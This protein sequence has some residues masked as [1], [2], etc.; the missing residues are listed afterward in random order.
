[1]PELQRRLL[2]NEADALLIS[3]E[4]LANDEF[5]DNVLSRI[6]A[7]IGLLE[8]DEAHCISDWGHD[9]RPDYKRLLN[10]LK[11]LPAN[12]PVVGTT[13]TANDR[14]IK[15]IESQLGGIR[16]QR[17]NLARKSL[18]LQ[19]IRM[20]TQA[21]R[22]A[23]ISDHINSLPGTGIIYVL[24]K[25]D[26]ENVARWLQKHGVLAKPYYGDVKSEE[27]P[28]SND[29]RLHLEEQLLQNKLKAVV[30]TTALGMGYDKP[31]LGFVVHYQAPGSIVGYYQQVGRAG[32]GI[33]HSVGILMAGKEDNRIHDYFRETAFP[34]PKWVDSILHTLEESDG[35]SSRKIEQ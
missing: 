23:W 2:K 29:Y 11:R 18:S 10:I 33:N 3:Q 35:L 31:D 1:M 20:R 16:I 14:V 17:G 26:A 13:A 15:D 27:F 25:R 6:T 28:D 21:E 4:R 8:V 34:K 24:T 19:T 32:R 22:L 9:F 12:T 7:A 30:A 5:V